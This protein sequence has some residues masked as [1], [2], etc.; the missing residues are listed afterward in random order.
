MNR[1]FTDEDVHWLEEALRLA[2]EAAAAGEVPVGAVVVED[3]EMIG[4]AR[5]RMIEGNDPT[6]HA[7]VLAL[8]QAA[9]R[10]RNYRLPNTTLYTTLEPCLLCAGAIVQ[11]RCRRV[12]F[13]AFDPKAGACGSAL[14]VLPHPAL[15][16]RPEVRG[17]L[18]A[19]RCGILLSTFFALR[20]NP[21][22]S[23]RAPASAASDSVVQ[24]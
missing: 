1:D 21:K 4:S 10:R 16:H 11:A 3:S 17:G 5:N 12:V 14:S 2:E 8:R 19:D 24:R 22:G 6:A 20:R 18:L 13:G 9:R 23:I 15:N 7:E